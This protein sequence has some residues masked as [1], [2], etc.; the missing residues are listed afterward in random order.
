MW[1]LKNFKELRSLE[2]LW[3][4]DTQVTDAGVNDLQAALPKLK[5]SPGR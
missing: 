5:I 2:T 3:L 4:F 1:G